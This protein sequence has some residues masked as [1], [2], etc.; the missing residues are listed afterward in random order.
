MKKYYY[1]FILF[2]LTAGL[3]KAQLPYNQ[4]KLCLDNVVNIS[5]SPIKPTKNMVIADFNGDGFKDYA[6]ADVNSQSIKVYKALGYGQGFL[7]TNSI[8]VSS[9]L[10]ESNSITH[11]D[12]NGDGNLDIAIC[13]GGIIQTFTS[14]G[15]GFNFNPASVTPIPAGSS[16]GL[17]YIATADFTSDFVDDLLLVTTNSSY[18]AG[19]S[20]IGFKSNSVS[21]S[22]A[23][24]SVINAQTLGGFSA[25]NRIN[26]SI[27]DINGDNNFDIVFTNPNK[28]DTFTVLKHITSSTTFSFVEIKQAVLAMA[29]TNYQPR[30]CAVG[31][32]NNDSYD[33][34]VTY[35]EKATLNTVS[36]FFGSP[37]G[38]V[39]GTSFNISIT[40][41]G[42]LNDFTLKDLNNDGYI[43]F[44][45]IAS[46]GLLIYLQDGANNAFVPSSFIF[47]TIPNVTNINPQELEVIDFDKNLINDIFIK[48]WKNGVNQPIVVPNFSYDNYINYTNTSLCGGNTITLTA[49][50]GPTIV[51]ST[52]SVSI[53]SWYETS[54]GNVLSASPSFTTNTPGN[55]YNLLKFPMPYSGS[56]CKL[57]TDTLAITFANNVTITPTSSAPNVCYGLPV[58]FSVTGATS[59]TWYPANI[60]TNILLVPNVYSSAVY[61]VVGQDANGCK[62]IKTIGVGL[63]PLNTNTIAT[64]NGT[65]FCAGNTLT[66]SFFG[67]QSYTWT[68]GS[69]NL[70]NNSF[71]NINPNASTTYSLIF[72]DNYGCTSYKTLDIALNPTC[73]STTNSITVYNA[74][75]PNGD[76]INDFLII[77]N[78]DKYTNT[79]VDIYDRWGV[80]IFNAKNNYNNITNYW[81]K[82]E[83]YSQLISTTY[84]YVINFGNGTVKKDWIE[85]L[86]D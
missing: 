38:L 55:F 59:Y 15:T 77:D 1:I 40:S 21:F 74:I 36:I 69:N 76:G 65:T 33:D 23:Y 24:S 73:T 28:T 39:F 48:T 85:I 5:T 54:S 68:D 81:P 71:I 47:I 14:T 16:L 6:I 3:L 57:T 25:S 45:G 78:I 20:V 7:A 82:K 4:N 35:S 86:K 2:A 51:P 46:S 27:G 31:D 80:L 10:N 13:Y 41:I 22:T 63:F 34:V 12:Y 84:F 37:I 83:D 26:F 61:T 11:G 44:V 75:T 18:T 52:S 19:V 42:T 64:S 70:G 29:P 9:T 72:T 17:T 50:T 43:D 67:V 79:T 58:T 60:A 8:S 66:L 30:L 49:V 32:I 62:D 53:H 56:N